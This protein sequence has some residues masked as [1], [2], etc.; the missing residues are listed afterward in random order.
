VS[1]SFF[2]R[3]RPVKKNQRQKIKDYAEVF[4]GNLMRPGTLSLEAGMTLPVATMEH[5][6]ALLRDSRVVVVES[7]GDEGCVE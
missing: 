7:I 4:L 2:S 3:Y 5:G 1:E 6:A